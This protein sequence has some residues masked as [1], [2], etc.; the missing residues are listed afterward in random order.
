MFQIAQTLCAL[1]RDIR[2]IK[3]ENYHSNQQWI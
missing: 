2:N 3:K 1:T